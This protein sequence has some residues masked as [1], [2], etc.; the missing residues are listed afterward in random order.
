MMPA[1]ADRVSRPRVCSREGDLV[2]VDDPSYEGGANHVSLDQA[3]TNV[4]AF[5]AWNPRSTP[6]VRPPQPEERP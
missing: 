6:S 3:R 5:G 4:R 2:K 1:D